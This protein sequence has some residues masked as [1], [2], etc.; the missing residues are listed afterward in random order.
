MQI[1]CDAKL[2]CV[3]GIYLKIWR[4]DL[5]SFIQKYF[6]FTCFREHQEDIIRACLEGEDQ[7]VCMP[8][9]S[10][11][12][13]CYQMPPLVTDKVGIVISPLIRFVFNSI[14]SI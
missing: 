11:K 4:E 3:A 13:L 7:F 5:I 14:L 10:G 9:A 12:S 1:T 8:T 2:D 6:G